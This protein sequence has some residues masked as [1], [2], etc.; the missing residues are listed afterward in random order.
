MNLH[1]VQNERLDR[2][3]SVEEIANIVM[4]AKSGS[5]CGCNSM[6]YDVLKNL[7]MTAI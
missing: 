1:D 3:I 2:N 4:Y 5:A 6:P 7:P